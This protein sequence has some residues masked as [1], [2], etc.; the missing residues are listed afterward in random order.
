MNCK[1][2]V[3]FVIILIYKR[4]TLVTV[5]KAER[6][7]VIFFWALLWHGNSSYSSDNINVRKNK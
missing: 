1:A 2:E 6:N 7:T 4:M 3:C 5:A